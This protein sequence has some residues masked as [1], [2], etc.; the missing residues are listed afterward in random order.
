[1]TSQTREIRSSI[2]N[3]MDLC[4]H[5]RELTTALYSEKG[6]TKIS[7]RPST[8]RRNTKRKKT[9]DVG[10]SSSVAIS[11]EHSLLGDDTPPLSS[12][13]E[14][15]AEPSEECDS[16]SQ[17]VGSSAGSLNPIH[18]L[19]HFSQAVDENVKHIR[20]NVDILIQSTDNSAELR[21]TYGA[22]SD[23]LDCWDRSQ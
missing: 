2:L 15:I 10:V 22:L 16:K 20:R 14:Q 7:F 17:D 23:A 21:D 3:L 4:L 12:D 1:M 18:Q 8:N 11:K 6:N 13:D 5:L 9:I 19:S